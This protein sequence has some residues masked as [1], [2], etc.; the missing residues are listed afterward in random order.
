VRVCVRVCVPPIFTVGGTHAV[1][2]CSMTQAHQFVV[3][4][5]YT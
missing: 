1:G 5:A 3:N 2:K 4:P